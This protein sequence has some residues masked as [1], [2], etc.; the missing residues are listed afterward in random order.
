MYE[1][2]ISSYRVM[3]NAIHNTVLVTQLVHTRKAPIPY[4]V[5]RISS[6][7]CLFFPCISSS[8][9]L[10]FPCVS[11]SLR[12]SVSSFLVS[13][14]LSVSSFLVSL[15]LSVSSFRVS[16]RLSVSSFLVSLRLFA[17]PSNRN[18]GRVTMMMPTK[19][20]SAP[21]IVVPLI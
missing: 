21:R 13:L 19:Q 9:C 18:E 11:P 12:L 15:R 5:Y 16:L 17:V 14:R 4:T 8:L 6:S 2:V 20:R 1:Y 7:L 3:Y 10:F